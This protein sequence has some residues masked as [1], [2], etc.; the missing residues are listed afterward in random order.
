M[1]AAFRYKGVVEIS[2]KR[3]GVNLDGSDKYG[4]TLL[5]LTAE[6][7][8]EGVVNI[9]VKRMDINA[10]MMDRLDSTIMGCFEWT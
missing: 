2:L 1:A 9:L 7:G 5:G 4:Q 8:L 3:T 6:Y 10:N